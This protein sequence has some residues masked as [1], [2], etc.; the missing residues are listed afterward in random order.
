MIYPR[1]APGADPD[2]YNKFQKKA[3]D[4]WRAA[5]GTHQNTNARRDQ[6]AKEEK[7]KKPKKKK[8][9]ALPK[10]STDNTT[11]PGEEGVDDAAKDKSGAFSST[12]PLSAKK[13][14]S[15]AVNSANAR[16]GDGDDCDLERQDTEG[17]SRNFNKD[18]N[19]ERSSEQNNEDQFNTHNHNSTEK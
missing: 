13:R 19:R 11:K 1:E 5:T 4:I 12:N 14:P 8:K 10:D 9:K 17:V 18:W 15:Q 16:G 2:L 3:N 6:Q 7:P